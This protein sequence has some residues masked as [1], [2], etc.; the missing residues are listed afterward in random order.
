VVKNPPANAGTWVQSLVQEYS[1]H[2]PCAVGQLSPC[3]AEA[4]PSALQQE[5]QATAM[6]S[7]FSAT[8]SPRSPQLEKAQ[9]Q[10]QR[11]SAAKIN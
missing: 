10:Q 6:R 1:M 8:S 3:T 11:L 2:L 4:C 9:V 5:K 7:P